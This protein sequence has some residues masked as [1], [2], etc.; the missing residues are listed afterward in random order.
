VIALHLIELAAALT[1][2]L[3]TC[4]HQLNYRLK[5]WLLSHRFPRFSSIPTDSTECCRS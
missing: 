4:F 3:S 5:V 2:M 1:V